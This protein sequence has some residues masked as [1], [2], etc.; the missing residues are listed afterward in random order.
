MPYDLYLTIGAVI[1]VF[2]IPSVVSAFSDRHAPRAASILVLIGGGLVA[3]AVT[4]KPGG[5]VLTEI[6]EV[7]VSVV[8][9]YIR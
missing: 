7:F 2:A 6:P 1:L 4:Q 5:Y 3:W 8:A 9:Q